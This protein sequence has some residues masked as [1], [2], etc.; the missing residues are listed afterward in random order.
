MWWEEQSAMRFTVFISIS[1][2]IK[3]QTIKQFQIRRFTIVLY[4]E[5]AEHAANVIK[6]FNTKGFTAD[7]FSR[8]AIKFPE[9][10]HLF[11]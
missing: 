9:K 4:Y 1:Q 2:I 11:D 8:Y 5:A 10:L 3:Y 6:R 7:F